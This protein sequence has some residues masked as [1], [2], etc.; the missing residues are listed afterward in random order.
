MNDET[1]M[2]MS[3]LAK[4]LV[5]GVLATWAMEKVTGF[6]WEHENEEARKQY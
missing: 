4:G 5:A 6:F 2:L 1:V 3:D